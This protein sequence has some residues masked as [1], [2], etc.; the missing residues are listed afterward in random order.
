[1]DSTSWPED[2]RVP[3]SSICADAREL[4][5][6]V[7]PPFLFNHSV[8]VFAWASLVARREV[9]SFD[10][11]VLYVACLLHDIGL[12]EAFDG[13]ECF[14]VEGGRAARAFVRERGWAD[15]RADVVAEAIRLHMQPRVILEDGP[16][17]YLLDAG[18]SL[19][20]SGARFGEVTRDD[21]ALVLL[22]APR[23]GFVEPFLALLEGQ[24][25]AKPGCMAELALK[26]GLRERMR[27]APFE[28]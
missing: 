21:V 12:T 15:D 1:L 20:C 16:E 8:R 9:V 4:C 6:L 23:Q 13:P 5:A 3:A 25:S 18:T 10:P 11:E 27:S 24:A 14:E 19:D 28:R 7:A 17:A 26:T 22:A 2:V